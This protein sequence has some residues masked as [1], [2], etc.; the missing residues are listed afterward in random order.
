M[1]TNLIKFLTLLLFSSHIIIINNIFTLMS[2][3]KIPEKFL[4]KKFV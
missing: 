4:T 1:V 3:I 2:V